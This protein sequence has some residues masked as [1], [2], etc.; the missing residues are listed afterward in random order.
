ME[1]FLY[2]CLVYFTSKLELE[3]L[4]GKE[5]RA[6]HTLTFCTTFLCLEGHS[7]ACL[8]T[9]L[10]ISIYARPLTDLSA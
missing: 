10:R 6:R 9:T 3:K 8:P 7:M 5:K 4:K 1:G 2:S